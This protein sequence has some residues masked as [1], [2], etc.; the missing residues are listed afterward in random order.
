MAS[1]IQE[2]HLKQQQKKSLNKFQ[3]LGLEIVQ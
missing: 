3:M 1:S 2:N